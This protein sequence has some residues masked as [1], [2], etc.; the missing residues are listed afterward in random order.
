MREES[1][2]NDPELAAKH[3]QAPIVP[4]LHAGTGASHVALFG[5]M[6]RAN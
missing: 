1:K 5:P 2:G 4:K 3:V 6:G